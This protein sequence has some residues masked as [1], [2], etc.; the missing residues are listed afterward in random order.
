M[1]RDF[2]GHW[3]LGHLGQEEEKVKIKENPEREL[4]RVANRAW[5]MRDRNMRALGYIERVRDREW[6]QKREMDAFVDTVFTFSLSLFMI[7][8]I[9]GGALGCFM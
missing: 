6:R 1:R 4:L 8:C 5:G 7:V 9:L 3:D 2:I